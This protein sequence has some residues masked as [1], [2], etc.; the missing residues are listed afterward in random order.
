[1]RP[2]VVVT[3]STGSGQKVD[4]PRISTRKS[5]PKTMKVQMAS[6]P[7]VSHTMGSPAAKSD[8]LERARRVRQLFFFPFSWLLI[9]GKPSYGIAGV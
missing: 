7:P 6:A 3:C 1:M 5:S 2:S 8:D 9:A 4:R